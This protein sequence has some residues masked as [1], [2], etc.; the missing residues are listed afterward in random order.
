MGL[1]S[2][3]NHLRITVSDFLVLPDWEKRLLSLTYSERVKK[4]GDITRS[5]SDDKKLTPEVYAVMMVAI[6][7]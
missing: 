7:D 5:L 2:L 6:H 4:L 3:C 1:M